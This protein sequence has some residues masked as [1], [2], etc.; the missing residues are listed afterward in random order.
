M[1]HPVKCSDYWG[2]V[3]EH[4]LKEE[5]LPYETWDYEQL[6]KYKPELRMQ[7]YKFA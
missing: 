6:V 4:V 3:A 2:S 7:A 5:G 1:N